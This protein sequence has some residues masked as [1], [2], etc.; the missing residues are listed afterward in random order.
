MDVL[1]HRA[2]RWTVG[3]TAAVLAVQLGLFFAVDRLWVAAV[4]VVLFQ[5][6]QAVAIA[7]NH[8]QHHRP[9][10]LWTPANRLYELVLF[11]QT[12]MPPY[13]ITL[14]HNLGHHRHYLDPEHDTLPWMRADG[15][16]LSLL[17]CLWRNTVGHL[18]DTV[19]IGRRFPRL[20]RRLGLWTVVGCLPLAL[21]AGLDPART[22]VV[23]LGP[24]LLA[25]VNVA[26]LGYL[27]HA[28]LELD[29]HLV[30]SR[31][32]ESRLYNLV[33]FNSG[34]HT[35]HHVKPGVHWSELPRLHAELRDAIPP[36]LR[37]DAGGTW[38]PDQAP[39][40]AASS[41]S[42]ASTAAASSRPEVFRAEVFR[43]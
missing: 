4:L 28:G 14:H 15:T 22:A 25:L 41:A 17:Q 6:V 24:M 21:V 23:F 30:A 13:L 3:F 12:G 16:R 10:F 5:P 34:Y 18:T 42:A 11:A 39:A 19:R 36:P 1:R 43:K 20:L 31:N 2:D 27:Q 38:R 9:V 37:G 32:I 35:A 40:G 8:Y 33:T 26:R 7:C 29:D